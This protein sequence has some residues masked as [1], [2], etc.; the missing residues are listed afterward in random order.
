MDLFTGD[1]EV[2]RRAANGGD[3]D[4]DDQSASIDDRAPRVARMHAAVDLNVKQRAVRV[5]AER[6]DGRF[7]DRDLLAELGTQ[8]KAEDID[9]LGF[10]Q[11]GQIGC[12]LQRRR[13]A[14]FRPCNPQ[15]GQVVRSVDTQDGGRDT[16]FPGWPLWAT[17]STCLGLS[18]DARSIP[19]TWAFVMTM[20]GSM[21]KNPEPS[22]I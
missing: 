11:L 7:A 21:A 6:G 8:G 10:H 13:Q 4:A 17:T 22:A 12:N 9:F 18:L 2:D 15:H 5:V 3:R 14:R 16:E 19:T 20:P 1:G